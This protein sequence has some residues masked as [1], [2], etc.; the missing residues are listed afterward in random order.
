MPK[1]P[2]AGE[3]EAQL[4]S[5]GSLKRSELAVL[6]AES[7]GRSIQFPP[8][9][10]TL[11]RC[12]VYGLQARSYGALAPA[13]RKQLLRIA[14]ALENGEKPVLAPSRP[15]IKPG[16]RMIREWH[17]ETHEVTAATKGFEYRGK[18]YGNLSQI[19]RR[20]TGTRWS[21]PAF[22]GLK[23]VSQAKDAK[24]AHGG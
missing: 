2:A 23:P 5:L 11:L 1:P 20:I 24:Q 18:R 8:H 9:I 3:I 16:T 7:F 12:L 17:G 6:W 19:A 21:G 4:A 13:T 10:D 15:S 14:E 22:F